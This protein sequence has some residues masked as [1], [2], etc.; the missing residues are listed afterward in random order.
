MRYTVQIQK[1]RKRDKIPSKTKK[2]LMR[3]NALT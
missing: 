3:H 2:I 1:S